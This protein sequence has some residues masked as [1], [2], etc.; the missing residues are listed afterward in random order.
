[1]KKSAAQPDMNDLFL[2]GMNT[3]QP[4]PKAGV[5]V[6][7][8]PLAEDAPRFDNILNTQCREHGLTGTPRPP[9]Y[10]HV[11]CGFVGPSPMV[12][13]RVIESFKRA[14]EAAVGLTPAFEIEFDHVMSFGGGAFALCKPGGN[15]AAHGFHHLL[16]REMMKQGCKFHK[17][18]PKFNPHMTLLYDRRTIPSTSAESIKWKVG[19]LALVRSLVGR[20][21]YEWLG[22]WQFGE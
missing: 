4:L 1:M 18:S 17:D 12:S 9:L 19:K 2:P 14:C 3:D 7:I 6:G 13:N 20:T 5:Y 15:E 11:T 8:F 16:Q 22:E 21:K 10:R